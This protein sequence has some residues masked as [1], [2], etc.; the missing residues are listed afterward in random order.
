M[1]L[2]VKMVSAMM[3]YTVCIKSNKSSQDKMVRT[4]RME[5][6]PCRK[7]TFSQAEG[8]RK[9]GRPKIRWFDIV[10]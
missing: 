5:N 6:S 9:K 3:N 8:F 7:I 4:L 1:A 10:L 2:Y